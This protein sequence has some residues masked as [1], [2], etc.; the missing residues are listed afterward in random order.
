MSGSGNQFPSYKNKKRRSL[1]RGTF[2]ERGTTLLYRPVSGQNFTADI[3]I[4]CAHNGA[5]RP[6]L[7]AFLKKRAHSECSGAMFAKR[8]AA[9]FHSPGSLAG[10]ALFATLS[11]IA[12]RCIFKRTYYNMP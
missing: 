11:L 6:E 8:A 3:N 9:G 4:G 12:F 7:T 5:C 2:I 10:L 1:M